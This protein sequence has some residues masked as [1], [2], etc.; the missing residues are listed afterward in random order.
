MVKQPTAGTH[1]AQAE[2]D[3]SDRVNVPGEGDTRTEIDAALDIARELAA[4]GIPIF[5]AP[6]DETKKI[7]FALPTDWERIRPDPSVVDT[8]R[9]GMALCAVMGCGLDLIDV[10]P[11]NGGTLEMMNGS[12]PAHYAIAATPSGGIHAFIASTGSGSRDNIFPGIDVK[13]GEADGSGRGFAFLAP[14][15]RP[16]KVTGA[17]SSYRWLAPPDLQRL[18][19][20]MRGEAQDVSG[21]A[22]AARIRELKSEGVAKIGGP[23][24]WREFVLSR[25]PQSQAA[26]ERAI[27]EK[28]TDVATWTTEVPNGFRT[29]LLRAAMTLGG[30]V[31]GGYLDEDTARRRL[32]EAAGQVWGTPDADDRLWITQG[33]TDGAAAPFYVYTAADEL[34]FSEV[35]QAQR[36]REEAARSGE[37]P[38]AP[39][40]WNVF[41]AI[42]TDPFDPGADSTDQG[43]AEQVA[44]RVYP[45]LRFAVDAGTWVERRRE[46]WRE[47]E[48]MSDWAISTVARLM[49]LG[50]PDL[51][52]SKADYT[53]QHWR[54]V[55]RQK[56]MDSGGSGKIS[57][58]LRSIVRGADHPLAVELADLDADPEVL[59]AGG[60]AWD[61]RAS[62]SGPVLAAETRGVPEDVPHLHTASCAPLAVPTPTWDRFVAAVWPDEA[63]R[64][65]AMR[66]LAIALAGYPDAALPVLYGPERTGKT[67]LVQ[68]IVRVLGTYGHA[69]DPRLL[70]GADNAHASVVYALKGRRLSFIDEGPRRGQLATER[71]KQLTGGGS[72][73]GNAMRANPVTF[74]PTHT[75]VMTTNDEPPVTDPALRARMRIILCDGDQAEVRARRQALTEAVWHNEAPGV[76]AKL[77]SECAAWIADPDSAGTDRAPVDLRAAVDE[78]AAAQ[79]PVGEWAEL[80]TVPSDPGMPASELYRRFATWFEVQATYRRM[81]LPTQTMFGRTLTDLGYPAAKGGPRKDRMYRPLSVLNGPGMP[82]PWEPGGSGGVMPVRTVDRTVADGSGTGPSAPE[83][84]S[85]TPVSSSFAEG[86]DSTHTTT[87]YTHNTPT[88]NGVATQKTQGNRS[89]PSDSPRIAP[90]SSASPATMPTLGQSAPTARKIESYPQAVDNSVDNSG[91]SSPSPSVENEAPEDPEQAA[92]AERNRQTREAARLADERKIS[93][94][95]ARKLMKEEARREAIAEASGETFELPAIV[96]RNGAIVAVSVDDAA[97]QVR[98]A[99]RR[100]GALT[101]D[102]ETSGYPVGHTHYVLR[103][104]QLGDSM[105]AVVF[106]PVEHAVVIRELLAEAPKLHAHSA[107]ADLVPLTHAGLVDAESAW[108]RMF[109]TVIPAKLADPASTGSDPGLKELAGAVLGHDAVAPRAEAARKAVF[110]A[111]KWLENTQV[112]TPPERS[113]WAQIDTRCGAMVLYAASDVLDTGALARAL[114]AIPDAVM[115]RERLAQRMTARVTHRGIRI[116]RERVEALTIEHTAART[117]IGATL[118]EMLGV[119]N[120]GSDRQIAVALQSKGAPLPISDKG[121]PSVAEGVLQKVI[122]NPSTA[123][124]VAEAARTVLAYRHHD[125]VLGTF[126]EPYR[127][128]CEIGDGRSRPTVYTLG[129]N[130]GR[131]SCVRPNAQQLPKKGGVRALYLADPDQLMIGA[132]FSGVEIRVAAALS[133]DPTLLR[134]LAEG[135]DLHAEIARQVWGESAGKAE[136]YRVKPIVFGRF[137]GG[138]IPTLSAQAGVSESIGAAVVDV[139]DDLAPQLAAWSAEIRNAVKRGHTQYPS[140]SGRIIHLPRDRNH[141]APNYCIQGTARELLVDALVRWNQTKWGSCTLL[142]VHDELDVWVP[143]EEAEEATAELVRCMENEIY[144]VKIV[145]DPST[146]SPFWADSV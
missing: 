43:L 57:K 92:R 96:G 27:T 109:D 141:A 10:D 94:A 61:L 59:W 83:N 126:L 93:K 42:G 91:S 18:R 70:A 65:W 103:S 31:G 114:P 106:D 131:M 67:A 41:S 132:D 39:P 40:P 98:E 80:C 35:A 21:R 128:L 11:R 101:V 130:T 29:V 3:A 23:D 71:L 124:E 122:A 16:S 123:P 48:D 17:P 62:L 78:M 4:A 46:A 5:V 139:L 136:R 14:T 45:A 115:E 38:G 20:V 117:E 134:F 140:Y 51:P 47:R 64:A 84:P 24:W 44:A 77:M 82:A 118:R 144:G 68:L 75:L 85:S 119:A 53:D 9:P 99:I 145:A 135:R 125:T 79:N 74:L 63:R 95:E 76:L 121:N 105:I 73:T 58:K 2:G 111:G 97:V 25:E 26:A 146:P 37:G 86:A 72:L 50:D 142:P 19:A 15:V 137:Y 102:V 107:T 120:P 87:N 28:L 52:K 8:W 81:P 32:E 113:G 13:S 55:R 88:P 36:A 90:Q 104:V 89:E 116:D 49:P 112:D 7:G 54:H 133:Q 6:P 138:G 56:F 129:T 30:Y 143:A 60:R 127:V 100:S 1:V 66:V 110:A 33:L 69:A 12:R 34:A 108:A 22:L